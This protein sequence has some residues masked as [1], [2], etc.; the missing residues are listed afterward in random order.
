[1]SACSKFLA[2]FATR[3]YQNSLFSF[4]VFFFSCFASLFLLTY[5]SF[6]TFLSTCFFLSLSLPGFCF[7]LTPCVSCF[8]RP[9]CSLIWKGPFRVRLMLHILR[10][11]SICW[12]CWIRTTS[13]WS[14]FRPWGDT[15]CWARETSSD[16]SW[17]SSSKFVCV[18]GRSLIKTD[19]SVSAWCEC[20]WFHCW[21]I[22][23]PSLFLESSISLYLSLSLRPELARAATTLYQHNLTGILETAVRATNAQFDSPEILKRLDVRLL[24]V[25]RRDW[26]Q[27]TKNETQ[28]D[29]K[30]LYIIVHHWMWIWCP[31]LSRFLLGTLVGTSS[32]WIIM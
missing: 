12:M 25:L 21:F 13:C 20:A 17:T 28:A 18:H 22:T 14:I 1:M 6:T 30:F 29:G 31:V 24:E 23:D 15:C 26:V 27:K 3:I 19:V 2:M 9:S 10:P 7:Y 32:V 5:S 16:T 8:Q 11:V 4:L